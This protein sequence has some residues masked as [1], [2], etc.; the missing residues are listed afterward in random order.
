M[1][2]AHYIMEGKTM[3][4]ENENASKG[5]TKSKM[6]E[7]AAEL[8]ERKLNGENWHDEMI[9]NVIAKD[10]YKRYKFYGFNTEDEVGDLFSRY[11]ERIRALINRYQ[12]FGYSFE[13]YLIT[14]LK[15]MIQSI[16][17]KHARNSELEAIYIS[18]HY[19]EYKARLSE[20]LKFNKDYPLINKLLTAFSSSTRKERIIIRR[21]ITYIC[22]K[23]ANFL[24]DDVIASIARITEMDVD[25]LLEFVQ[26]ARDMELGCNKRY[27]SY[28]RGRDAAWMRL[29]INQ[30]KL[31]NETDEGKRKQ[32]LSRIEY[33]R[34]R[35]FKSR[36]F[37]RKAN[38]IISNKNV[39][40]ILGI[41]K[42]TVDC[43]VTRIISL[44]KKVYT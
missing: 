6:L 32:Y 36:Q 8:I 35:L 21:R 39:A 37:M 25:N 19:Q 34:Y 33:E 24:H 44:L 3:M 28:Q 2:L 1:I 11:L 9:L 17:R 30:I 27:N 20:N 13:T 38:R 40:K 5:Q 10:V 7:K 42:G 12:N 26:K 23:F 14:S 22:L 41:P 15:F 4:Q 18:D 43:G 31:Y 29:G 16:K